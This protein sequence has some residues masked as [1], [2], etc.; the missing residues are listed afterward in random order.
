VRTQPQNQAP[1]DQ[2]DD[3]CD[4]PGTCGGN[5]GLNGGRG[6]AQDTI[7]GI[8]VHAG[9]NCQFNNFGELP[10][11]VIPGQLSGFVFCDDIRNGRLDPG[12][13]V[14][15]NVRIRLTGGNL[16]TPLFTTTDAAGG[17]T[18]TNLAPGTY[19]ISLVD[20]PGSFLMNGTTQNV[21]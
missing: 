2:F 6:R 3:G 14:F 15:A 1:L 20:V 17:F 18:F 13:H 10:K 9:D 5:V 8:T 12:E 21:L 16:T 7:M 11:S 4:T 19:Q